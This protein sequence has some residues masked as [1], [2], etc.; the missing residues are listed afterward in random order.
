MVLEPTTS[1][2]RV[3]HATHCTT[4][5]LQQSLH[6]YNIS[7]DVS[8]FSFSTRPVD[9]KHSQSGHAKTTARFP[10]RSGPKQFAAYLADMS[11]LML[12]VLSGPMHVPIG[13]V[14]VPNLGHLAHNRPINGLFPIISPT[15][16]RIGELHVAIVIESLM[17]KSHCLVNIVN[18]YHQQ[19][20]V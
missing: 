17:G 13:T 4:P 6:N 2:L 3:R 1:T 16:E 14:E 8:C 10:V 15:E 19:K 7:A 5:P 12:E 20:R 18:I 9:L 11:S